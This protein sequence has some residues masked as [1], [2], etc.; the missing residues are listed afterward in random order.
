MTTPS[1]TAAP[2]LQFEGY[3]INPGL[4]AT[5]PDRGLDAVKQAAARHGLADWDVRALGAD[6]EDFFVTPPAGTPAPSV[7]DAWQQVHRFKRDR[8]VADAEPSFLAPGLEPAPQDL[9]VERRRALEGIFGDAPHKGGSEARLWA[10]QRVRCQEAW[11][12]SQP[13]RGTALGKG[14]RIAHPDTGA[15][16][17][18]RLIKGERVLWNEGYDFMDDD[19]LA[20]DP[21]VGAHPGHGTAT[22]SVIIGS[23]DQEFSGI[24]PEALLIPYRVSDS[25]IHFSWGRLCQALYRAV[26]SRCHIVSMSLGGP[27]GGGA[28]HRAI[29]NAVDRGLILVSAAGNHVGPVIFPARYPETLAVAACACDDTMW[30]GSSTGSSVDLTAPGESVWRALARGNGAWAI[31]RSSGTS[32]AT[33]ITAG[34]C[35]LWLAH[36]GYDQLLQRY[37]APRLAAVFRDVLMRDGVDTPPG[38]QTG[39][40]GGGILNIRA[41]LAAPLPER[42]PATAGALEAFRREQNIGLDDRLAEYFPEQD[43]DILVE[44]FKKKLGVTP[45]RKLALG[46]AVGDELSFHIAT[47]AALREEIETW[48][49]QRADGGALEALPELKKGSPRF[50]PELLTAIQ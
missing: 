25:V 14:I 31:E 50:S 17:H 42:A 21:L 27:W 8:L 33:A 43:R 16:R 20:E 4:A 23:H 46:A 18:P 22:G 3:I 7:A 40:C 35:A 32:Y 2:S 26:E 34:A 9:T 19:Q 39:V 44:A 15:A 49:A 11:E 30:S 1:T 36:H 47:D 5:D 29:Q 37:G 6:S 12:L 28:L 13:A 38:W 45:T 48:C 10:L 24:A 41:L